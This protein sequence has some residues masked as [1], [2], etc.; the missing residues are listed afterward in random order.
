MHVIKLFL[1]G[2]PGCGKSRTAKHVAT[3]IESNG[4]NWAVHNFKDYNILYEMAKED[5]LHQEF[6]LHEDN[7]FDV[8]DA[9]K[10]DE[11]LHELEK[12]VSKHLNEISIHQPGKNHLIII[13]LARE[14]YDDAFEQ[15][16]SNFLAD[17]Y[18]LLIDTRFKKCK[19]RIR[20]RVKVSKP[21]D[22]DNHNIS[23]YVMK[24]YY[25]HQQPIT[26]ENLLPRFQILAN[27]G[28]W[29]NF[30]R[31]VEPFIQQVLKVH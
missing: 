12:I 18:F 15:F 2:R 6:V 22:L 19:K 4:Q 28:S 13:E 17:S 23:K 30:T 29:D 10:L 21:D 9:A 8:L 25:L 14:N 1:L 26:Q 7:S 3:I 20:K 24:T 16:S 31:E 27:N 5:I 11:A